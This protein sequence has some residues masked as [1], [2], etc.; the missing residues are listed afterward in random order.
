MRCINI[1][2]LLV[3]DVDGTLT[4]GSIILDNSRMESR[5]FS[6]KDG[7]ILKILPTLGIPVVFLTGRSSEIV[8]MRGKELGVQDILQGIEDKKAVLYSYITAHGISTEN[9]SYIGDDLN[10][11]AAMRSCGHKACP[12]DAVVEIREIC[13]YVSPYKGGHGAVRDI[14]ENLLKRENRYNEFLMSV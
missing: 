2:S 12:A 3:C 8:A 7:L 13:D 6:V 9:V 1:I 5:L 14:C 4:D 10:D 11:Y